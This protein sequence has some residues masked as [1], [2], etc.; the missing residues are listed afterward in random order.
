[1]TDRKNTKRAL[2][3]SILSL[4]L[5]VS[6]LIGS[7]FAWFTDTATT[8]V[9][10]IQ[11]G[12]LDVALM[13][14]DSTGAWVNA[15]NKTLDFKT[16]DNRT[17]ILWEP[18]CTYELPELK[19]VNDGNLA[20]KY[21]MFITGVSGDIQLADVLDVWVKIGDGEWNKNVGT[22]SQLMTDTDGTAYGILL[23]AGKQI[24]SAAPDTEK[25]VTEIGETQSY[26]IALHMQETAGNAYQKLAL[27]NMAVT[28]YAYQYTYEYDSYGNQYDK[29]SM[30]VPVSVSTEAELIEALNDGKDIILDADIELTNTIAV[31]DDNNTI[32]D[33]K[34]RAITVATAGT[35]AFENHGTLT[36]IDTVGGGSI[37]ARIG[38]S[39]YGTLVLND[40]TIVANEQGGAAIY[41][42]AGSNA[43]FTMNGGTL[44][45]T[46]VGS[47]ADSTGGAC[48]RNTGDSVTTI[49]GGT[50][51]SRSARTYAIISNGTLSITPAAGKNVTMTAYRGIAIDD[52]TAN[53]NGGTFTVL[54]ANEEEGRYVAYETYYALYVGGNDSIVTVNGGTFTAPV[55]SVWR[56]DWDEAATDLVINGGTFNGSLIGN[57]GYYPSKYIAVKGGTF[58][59][60][61]T[62]YLAT[63][64][65]VSDNGDGTFTV[66]VAK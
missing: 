66:S 48:I 49:T 38:V 11:A 5:C 42:N 54:D 63:G 27:N 43:N 15:E 7:T 52:G 1:M 61:P 57:A 25:A 36:I 20:L 14:K 30:D 19:I 45:A 47:Y 34:D 40:G 2:F 17:E 39:N 18:G 37:T 59:E 23:P 33:L 26:T 41:N 32:L 46:F 3:T 12:E 29:D 21:N 64:Y 8:G 65:V 51:E 13:M 58:D 6:M 4:L 16:A 10:T 56:P 9:N 55:S 35:S 44:K 31:A 62:A 50:L 28:V 60:D 53:I 22:L 24:D